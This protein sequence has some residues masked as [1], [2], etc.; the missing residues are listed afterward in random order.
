MAVQI[1][2]RR[3]TAAEWTAANPILTQGEFGYES[4]TTKF[5]IGDGTASWTEL[6]YALGGD[7]LT[8]ATA[9]ATYLTISDAIDTYL[10]ISASATL[11]GGSSASVDNGVIISSVFISPEE[12]FNVLSA[13]AA[14][15]VNI[16]VA[17]STAWV[18]DNVG[19]ENFTIN[20]RGDGSNSLNSL[21]DTG[22]AITVG[23]LNAT[24]TTASAF[25]ATAVQVDGSSITPKWINNSE[26]PSSLPTQTSSGYDSYTITLV[27]T[28]SAEYIALG[29]WAQ[30]R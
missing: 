16:D 28:A 25:F 14:G 17:T 18:Y 20:I 23:L 11:G 6:G 19:N 2:L 3:G 4:D 10:P 9:S 22:D 24:G 5:K 21:L 26:P 13:S 1:Q 30:Y 29:S 8:E 15:T 7:V 27:K 12:R